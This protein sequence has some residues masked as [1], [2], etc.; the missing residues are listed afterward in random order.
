MKIR[1]GVLERIEINGLM[2]ERL[3]TVPPDSKGM[4]VFAHGSGSSGSPAI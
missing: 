4:V 1:Q 3:L 2:L